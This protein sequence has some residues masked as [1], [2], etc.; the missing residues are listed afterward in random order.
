MS[1][2]L[3]VSAVAVGLSSLGSGVVGMVAVIRA[4][5]EDIPDVMRAINQR[6]KG[7]RRARRRKRP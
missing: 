7:A 6:T 3:M 1:S 2:Y 5:P 4:K